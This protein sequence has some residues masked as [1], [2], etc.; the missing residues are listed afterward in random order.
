MQ[1]D[2]QTPRENGF[3]R[4][5]VVQS[6]AV[7]RFAAKPRFESHLF[8]M[9]AVRDKRFETTHQADYMQPVMM[10][11]ESPEFAASISINVN[12]FT[13]KPNDRVSDFLDCF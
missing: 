1:H 5:Q 4:A 3:T 9:D 10:T 11:G 2:Y 7:D 13:L 6:D 8:H 12:H